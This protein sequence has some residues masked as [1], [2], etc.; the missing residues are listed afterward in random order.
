[1]GVPK[2]M[3]AVIPASPPCARGGVLAQYL[4]ALLSSVSHS[5]DTSP[6]LES[7]CG[8]GFSCCGAWGVTPPVCQHQAAQCSGTM[9][10]DG[11]GGQSPSHSDN[12]DISTRFP[13]CMGAEEGV[14]PV[15]C[16]TDLPHQSCES[17]CGSPA[18]LGDSPSLPTVRTLQLSPPSSSE[19]QGPGCARG[20]RLLCVA[21][22]VG[23]TL[24]LK[25]SRGPQGRYFLEERNLLYLARSIDYTE[26]GRGPGL[27]LTACPRLGGCRCQS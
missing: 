18:A 6:G 24:A 19:H 5:C 22:K 16:G 2:H 21:L 15:G 12:E 25:S 11:Q 8:G 20:C 4:L 1:M 7:K 3:S 27:L 23:G 13:Q 14:C 9:L 17:C 26:M 10:L